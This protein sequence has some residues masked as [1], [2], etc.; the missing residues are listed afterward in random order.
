MFPVLTGGSGRRLALDDDGGVVGAGENLLQVE[1]A[2]VVPDQ[3]QISPA[4]LQPE[5]VRVKP[6]PVGLSDQQEGK[7]GGGRDQRLKPLP[8]RPTDVE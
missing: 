4:S 2:R 1:T 5:E 7:V 3:D 6:P 8:H